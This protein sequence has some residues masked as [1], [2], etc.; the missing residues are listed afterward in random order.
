MYTNYRFQ[1]FFFGAFVGGTIGALV[2][3]LFTTEKGKQLQEGISEK[4]EELKEN[5]KE[6]VS[7]AAGKVEEMKENAKETAS[8]AASKVEKGIDKLK[9]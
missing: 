5:A 2:T 6:K 4:Y 9:S 8:N 7:N 1:D 3:M